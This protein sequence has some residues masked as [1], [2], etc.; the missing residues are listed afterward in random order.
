MA[1]WTVIDGMLNNF[2]QPMLIK[3]EAELPLLLIMA[4][5]LGG[6]LTFG[7]IG[8]FVGPVTLA[9]VSYVARGVGQK[10]EWRRGEQRAVKPAARIHLRVHLTSPSLTDAMG[11]GGA[12]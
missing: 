10:G 12:L 5:V 1:V 4:G 9:V 2:I 11:R 7:I 6:L 3:K 8:L